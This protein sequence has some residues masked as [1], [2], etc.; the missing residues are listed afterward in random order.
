MIAELE[1][2]SRNERI[3]ANCTLGTSL[4]LLISIYLQIKLFSI[5]IKKMGFL[6]N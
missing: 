1:S 6:I 5:I 3:K 2:I 4:I